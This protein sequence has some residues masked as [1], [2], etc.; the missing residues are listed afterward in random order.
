MHQLILASIIALFAIYKLVYCTPNTD[1]RYSHSR[2]KCQFC[3]NRPAVSVHIVRLNSG[4]NN[5]RQKMGAYLPCINLQQCGTHSRCNKDYLCLVVPSY[6]KMV[7]KAQ[8]VS[9]QQGLQQLKFT[10]FS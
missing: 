8:P 10:A 3:T 4:K 9:E 2:T 6:K 1:S 5:R 7:N